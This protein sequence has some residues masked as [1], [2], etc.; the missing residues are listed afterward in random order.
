MTEEKLKI[1]ILLIA[2][3]LLSCSI[4]CL[5]YGKVY[6]SFAGTVSAV[7]CGIVPAMKRNGWKF[8]RFKELITICV[9]VCLLYGIWFALEVYQQANLCCCSSNQ[10]LIEY[11]LRQ[12]ASEN[13]GWFPDKN[14]AEAFQM[15]MLKPDKM[16]G[17]GTL[18]CANQY[19]AVPKGNAN[20]PL[21]E[22]NVSFIYHGGLRDTPENADKPLIW[23]K[24]GNHH[25]SG[26]V[27]YV[28]GEI[29]ILR[30]KKWEEFQ[31]KWNKE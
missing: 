22:D 10:V 20:H 25:F 21:T 30:Y 9:M 6:W 7:I 12:Y 11:S 31:K 23:D 2:A 28:G 1:K 27:I 17:Y 18:I 13:D 16:I 14:G 29:R 8:K 4:A 19:G 26:V 5:Y 24:P 3:I 15:L